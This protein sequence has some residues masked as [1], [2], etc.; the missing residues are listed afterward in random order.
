MEWILAGEKLQRCRVAWLAEV[1]TARR[2]LLVGEGHGRFLAEC[3]RTFPQT[4]FTC[5][6]ASHGM[7]EQS[8][9][10]WAK[11]GGRPERID[12]IQATLPEWT[13]PAGAFDLIVTNFFLDC[14]SPVQL[15][16][17]IGKLGAGAQPGAHWLVA[18]FRLPESGW[19]RL[20]ARLIL[21]SAYTFFRVATKLPARQLTAPDDLLRGAGFEMLARRVSEWGL[22]HADVWRRT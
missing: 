18:D 20:R 10:V 3:A 13:P 8:R 19:R 14:F 1:K 21:M 17:V 4:Q 22:L 11:A 5:V 6:D 15:A 16:E 2:A 7:L 12:F 9:A